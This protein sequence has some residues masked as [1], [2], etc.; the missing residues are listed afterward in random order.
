MNV[1]L[2]N[3]PPAT[4]VKPAPNSPNSFDPSIDVDIVLKSNKEKYYAVGNITFSCVTNRTEDTMYFKYSFGDGMSEPYTLSGNITHTYL[5]P[6][7][8]NYTVDAVAVSQ[9]SSKA[10]HAVHRGHISVLGEEGR[11][12]V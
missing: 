9:E 1:S 7:F 10:F 8:Y 11:N 2:H 5:V 4:S 3:N 6:G 12:S